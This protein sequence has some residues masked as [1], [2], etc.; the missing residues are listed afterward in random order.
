MENLPIENPPKIDS[1]IPLQQDNL[2]KKISILGVVG[3]IIFFILFYFLFFS[4]PT[5]FPKGQTINIKEGMGLRSVSSHL[6]DINVIRSRVAF[7]AFVIIFGGEKYLAFGDYFFEHK[8]PVF[9]V[10]RRL[11]EGEKRLAQIRV[12][13][14]EGFNVLEIADTYAG[15]LKSFNKENFLAIALDQ[16]GYLFPDTYF[17]LST[18]TEEDV[19]NAMSTN[20]EKKIAP[21]RAEMA[22]IGK[23]E[24]DIIVMASIIEKEAKGDVDREVI[25]GILW[26]RISIGMA[27]QADAAPITYKERGLPEDP[28]CNPG[29][30]SIKA[31]MHP[32]MSIYFYY[33][34]DKEGKIHYAR[35]FEEH[36]A[37]KF[38]YLK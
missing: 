35:N 25:S 7:E 34:H 19:I 33:L 28:I 8:T 3:V 26:N 4:A 11:S 1:D 23:S 6:K 38:K 37:N 32:K 5:K 20:F 12:T 2:F 10:A 13:I 21:L 18:D 15:K 16:E 30:E 27:L 36:K 17:F 24:K 9:E 31:A 29:L 22:Q 14:P